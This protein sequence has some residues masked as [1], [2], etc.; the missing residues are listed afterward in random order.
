MDTLMCMQNSSNIAQAR[1]RDQRR[2]LQ[3]QPALD[4]GVKYLS[5]VKKG[6]VPRRQTLT[7]GQ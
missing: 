2:A 6:G 7:F 5:V 1:R 4:A 3:R